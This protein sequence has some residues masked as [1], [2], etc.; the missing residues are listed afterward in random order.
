[1]I[2]RKAGKSSLS[3]TQIAT[4][5]I[6]FRSNS[7][8]YIIEASIICQIVGGNVSKVAYDSTGKI[9]LEV[10]KKLEDKVFFIRS[11]HIT[12]AGDSIANDVIYHNNCWARVRSKV[13]P[14]KEKNGSI[15]H[16]LSKIEII[17]FKLK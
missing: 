8:P 12:T 14:R 9:M 1:M 13:R 16:T 11:N 2:K 5:R 3:S 6:A 15:A 17:L 4:E 7:E 10:S